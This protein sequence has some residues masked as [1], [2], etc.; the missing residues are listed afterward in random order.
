[1]DG[2]AQTVRGQVGTLLM[3]G[4]RL[5]SITAALPLDRAAEAVLTI[6]LNW[7]NPAAIQTHGWM[8]SAPRRDLRVVLPPLHPEEMDAAFLSAAWELGAWDVSR[9]ER[10]P[11]PPEA[12]PVAHGIAHH[13]ADP[14]TLPGLPDNPQADLDV[15]EWIAACKRHGWMVWLCKPLWMAPNDARHST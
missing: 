4:C 9:T 12:D 7:R 1:M 11:L 14:Y 5:S 6:G 3:A 8:A 13:V 10:A 2:L 15:S